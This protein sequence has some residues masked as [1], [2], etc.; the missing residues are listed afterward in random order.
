MRKILV[1]GVSGFTGRYFTDL[2]AKSAPDGIKIFGI[3]KTRPSLKAGDFNFLRLDLSDKDRV[4]KA[5]KEIN[6]QRILH[7]AGLNFG[8]DYAELFKHNVISTRNILDGLVKN[9]SKARILIVGSAAEYGIVP[10]KGLP[11][12]ESAALRPVS[13]Y[14]VSKVVQDLLALQYHATF[15]LD[16]VIARPFN[17]VGPGQSAD[18]VCGSIVKQIKDICTARAKSDT[19]TIGNLYTSRD[20]IDVRDVVKA[21]W[22]LLA[23]G[24]KFSGEIFNIG[25]G[26]AYSVSEIIN[27]MVNYCGKKVRIRQRAAIVRRKDIPVQI[28]DIKKIRTVTGWKPMIPIELSLQEMYEGISQ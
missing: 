25:S 26:K 28:A 3:D 1:T 8:R 12:S 18:F 21:Y 16:I 20:F 6:P 14:G 24:K 5:I 15:G 10:Q 17:I 27:L 2:L 7:L 9:R 19:L 22:K 11:I 4:F 13:P 23:C